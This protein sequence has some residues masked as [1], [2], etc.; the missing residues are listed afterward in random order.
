MF[1]AGRHNLNSCNRASLRK[2]GGD[3]EAL[4]SAMSTQ[5]DSGTSIQQALA[6][7]AQRAVTSAKVVPCSPTSSVINPYFVTPELF[8]NFKRQPR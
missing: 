7:V 1:Q 4:A 8:P 2:G 6:T 5:Q 3:S